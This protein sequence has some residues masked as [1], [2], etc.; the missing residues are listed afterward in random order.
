LSPCLKRIP[1]PWQHPVE[2]L[3]RFYECNA[4]HASMFRRRLNVRQKKTASCTHGEPQRL[5]E[6]DA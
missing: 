2:S 4:P 5:P 1:A 6:C 3:Q